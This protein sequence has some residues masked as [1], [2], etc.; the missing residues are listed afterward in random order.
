[1][2]ATDEEAHAKREE[3][4][5]YADYEGTYALFGGWTGVD[6][7][8]Y[9][10]DENFLVTDSPRVQSLIRR[11]AALVPRTENQPWTKKRIAEC[12]SIS[13]LQAKL[14][15]SPTTIADQLERWVELTDVDGFNVIHVTN[16][17]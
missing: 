17:G 14:I 15:G 3:Y 2:A 7:S 11:W 4:L 1:M 9:S 8:K 12:L 10:N 6:L 13:G 5:K 16:P